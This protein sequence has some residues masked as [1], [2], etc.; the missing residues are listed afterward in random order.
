MCVGHVWYSFRNAQLQK[1]GVNLLEMHGV[2]I[3]TQA[4]PG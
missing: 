3:A 1:I 4:D 2:L